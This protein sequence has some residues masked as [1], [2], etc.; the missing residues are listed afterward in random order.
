MR[1]EFKRSRQIRARLYKILGEFSLDNLT[2]LTDTQLKKGGLSDDKIALIRSIPLSITLDDLDNIPGIGPQTKKSLRLRMGEPG[3]FLQEDL[4]IR[5]NLQII[6]E[7]EKVPTP[8]QVQKIVDER[9]PDAKSAVS[10]CLWRLKHESAHK[11]FNGLNDDDF[12]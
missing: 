8:S 10:L 9:W 2:N 4:Y 11:F 3:I 5:K 7:L 12:W 1:I 6:F